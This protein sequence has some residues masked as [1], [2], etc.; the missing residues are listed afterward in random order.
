[1]QIS[2]IKFALS[3]IDV[4]DL[5]SVVAHQMTVD[6]KFIVDLLLSCRIDSDI[7]S[8]PFFSRWCVVCPTA[9]IF[10]VSGSVRQILIWAICSR[11]P[12]PPQVK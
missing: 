4:P 8:A 3:I 2:W 12:V 10:L 6:P 7:D 11:D 5:I 9:P 1:M